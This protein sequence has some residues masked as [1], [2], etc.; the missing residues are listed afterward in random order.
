MSDKKTPLQERLSKA[1]GPPIENIN[2]VKLHEGQW[3]KAVESKWGGFTWLIQVPGR[4]RSDGDYVKYDGLTDSM[5][6]DWVRNRS[7]ERNPFPPTRENNGCVEYP[8]STRFKKPKYIAN[9][10]IGQVRQNSRGIW[11]KSVKTD[12]GDYD[13][14]ILNQNS[15]EIPE[16]AAALIQQHTPV[17][18]PETA[19]P[20][21]FHFGPPKTSVN[22]PQT[23]AA[24]FFNFG[25]QQTPVNSVQRPSPPFFAFGQ[26]Q[27]QVNTAQH[28]SPPF[29][30]FGQQTPVVSNPSG[31]RWSLQELT[32]E[33][34]AI[35]ENSVQLS[36]Q[37]AKFHRKLEQLAYR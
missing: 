22:T 20:S 36:T 33:L 21:N 12:E 6:E 24:P 29:V 31:G 19:A 28:P 5:L 2:R 35:S 27:T 32:A 14:K 1:L 17:N 18:T 37:I 30:D 26:Q 15:D 13:W 9:D 34:K 10:C 3:Y 11:Y 8:K 4:D 7:P 23:A 25:Q 16:N